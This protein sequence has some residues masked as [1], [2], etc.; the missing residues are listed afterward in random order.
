MARKESRELKVKISDDILRGGYANTLIVTHTA[1]E[2]VLD[3][4]LSLPPQG[5]INSRVIVSPGHLKRIIRA[6]QQNLTGYEKKHGPVA[7]APEPGPPAEKL[8]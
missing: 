3:F 5:V 4:V 2:F 8:H 7:E 6:L 1:E